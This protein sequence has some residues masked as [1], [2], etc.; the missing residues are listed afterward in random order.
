MYEI[1]QIIVSI[2]PHLYEVMKGKDCSK[3]AFRTSIFEPCFA[4]CADFFVGNGSAYFLEL[5]AVRSKKM[6]DWLEEKS[7]EEKATRYENG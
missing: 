4:Y 7:K 5:D 1:G 6:L 2:G 3:C